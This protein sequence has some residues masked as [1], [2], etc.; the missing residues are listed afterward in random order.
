MEI[1]IEKQEDFSQKEIK[2]MQALKVLKQ[3]CIDNCVNCDQCPLWSM[4]LEEC[5]L[6][7][8]LPSEIDVEPSKNF[9][10]IK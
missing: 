10:A 5:I 3:T 7:G 2:I 1:K 4:E 8:S 9:R 6:Y